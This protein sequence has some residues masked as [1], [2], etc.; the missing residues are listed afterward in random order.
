MG[1]KKVL[2][3]AD[4]PT[5]IVN[6]CVDHMIRLMSDRYEFVKAYDQVISKDAFNELAKNV[7]IIHFNSWEM[8]SSF[9]DLCLPYMNKTIVT[10]RSHRY[11][12]NYTN[13]FVAKCRAV[14]GVNP[15]IRI[16]M[17]LV[18]KNSLYIPDGIEP[19]I[20]GCSFK[21][22]IGF[23]GHTGDPEDYKGYKLIKQAC[24]ELGFDIMVALGGKTPEDM[25][26]FYKSIDAYVC[27]S[28]AEGFSTTCMEA[29]AMNLPVITTHCGIPATLNV[30][31]VDRSVEGI[32]RGLLKLFPSQQVQSFTWESACNEYAKLYE[33]I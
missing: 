12:K 9:Y 30:T 28:V 29:M 6:R 31:E 32:K 26:D 1:I 20:L 33:T 25:P 2:I 16:E 5:W 8:L 11:N 22:V 7:D 27:A 13:A 21:P 17:C 14:T 10:V 3:L 24:Q 4:H 19:R 23:S 18:N 15:G